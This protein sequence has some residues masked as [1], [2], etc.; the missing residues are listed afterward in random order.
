[1]IVPLGSWTGKGFTVPTAPKP[2]IYLN[3]DSSTFQVYDTIFGVLVVLK[4]RPFTPGAAFG[5]FGGV[6]A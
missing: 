2:S 5:G 1:M 6:G 3:R 4:A